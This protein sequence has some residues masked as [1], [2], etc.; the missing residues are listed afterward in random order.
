MKLPKTP[1]GWFVLT[2][3]SGVGLAGGV[4]TIWQSIALAVPI[5]RS[6]DPP[7]SGL[8]R[9]TA[10]EQTIQQLND[11]AKGTA[12]LVDRLLRRADD[13]ELRR[14]TNRRRDLVAEFGDPPR[15]DAI[16]TTLEDLDRRIMEMVEKSRATPAPR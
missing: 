5:A 14:L 10:A 3:G 15:S 16:R 4:Y 9:V 2:A 6:D 11:T 1:W 7:W 13:D 8:V 12:A